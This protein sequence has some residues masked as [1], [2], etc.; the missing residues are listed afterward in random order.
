MITRTD[1]VGFTSRYSLIWR[2]HFYAGLFVLPFILILSVTGSIYLFKPQIE[3]WE[4]RAYLGLGTAG[5]VSPDR[6]LGVVMAANPGARFD[7]YRLPRQAGDAAMIQL[8]LSDGSQR[9]VFVSPQGKV[10]G[11]LTPGA[12]VEDTVAEIHGSLLLGQWGDWLVELAASWTIVMI[13]TGLYLWWPRPFR[14]AGTLWPRLS[15]NGRPLLKDIHRVTGFWIAGLVL[16]TLASG[17]PWAGVWGSSFKWARTELGLVNG[18]QNWKVGAGGGHAGH[19]GMRAAPTPVTIPAAS[20]PLS[21]FVAKAEAEELTFPALVLPPYAQQRFGPPTGDEWTVKSEAQNRRLGRQVSYDP[22]S[23]A[24][25]RRSGFADQ[26]PIDQIVN[27]GV[28]WHEGQLFG[29]VNQLIGL[30]TAVALLSISILGVVMWWRRRPPGQIGAP[31]NDPD[32]PIRGLVA[33]IV[34]CSI[35]LPMLGASLIFVWLIDRLL[36]FSSTARNHTAGS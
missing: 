28:A 31:Q 5:A 35:L 7:S 13:L 21:I 9:Q 15:L 16:V 34:I 22:H 3:R 29:L 12:R 25:S 4:E 18:Q 17:L 6:Q 24:E 14:A 30:A 8:S 33:L 23:G 19:H 1:P 2:W 36:L 20:L 10:L 32:V 26:H 11:N 27:T